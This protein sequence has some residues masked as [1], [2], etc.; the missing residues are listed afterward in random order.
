MVKYTMY[1]HHSLRPGLFRALFLL[2][3]NIVGV[4]LISWNLRRERIPT[5]QIPQ[6]PEPYRSHLIRGTYPSSFSK[7]DYQERN[8][9]QE[10]LNARVG[11]SFSQ[12]GKYVLTALGDTLR[13]YDVASGSQ[14]RAWSLPTTN[15]PGQIHLY[16][17][18]L[19]NRWYLWCYDPSLPPA[20]YSVT[21][22]QQD[23]GNPLRGL[24]SVRSISPSGRYLLG[25]MPYSSTYGPEPA[26]KMSLHDRQ[27]R[28]TA[29]LDSPESA[30]LTAYDL[31]YDSGAPR[32]YGRDAKI[33]QFYFFDL[34][35]GKR[36]PTP[37]WLAKTESQ[38]CRFLKDTVLTAHKDGTIMV[39]SRANPE[40]VLQSYPTGIRNFK[41]LGIT[42]DREFIIVEGTVSL[43][44]GQANTW[45][46]KALDT[47]GKGRHQVFQRAHPTTPVSGSRTDD[48]LQVFWTGAYHLN[49]SWLKDSRYLRG[50]SYI[51][52]LNSQKQVPL[53]WEIG[54]FEAAISPNK[55]YLAW[56][57]RHSGDL[58]IWRTPF[59]VKK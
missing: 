6:V 43:K 25:D 10:R 52:D 49:R 22:D 50:E 59:S 4:A 53:R 15:R 1:P 13:L 51:G 37:E 44:P 29:V 2:L 56:T 54:A 8:R 16:S 26:L 40:R 31:L 57:D 23:L 19:E 3:I 34:E 47:T 9:W 24:S 33:Q 35:T 38:Y 58:M 42:Q 5:H 14:V 11:P 45:F 20:V 30:T 12:D 46:S 41:R 39:R 21:P 7:P 18:P 32:L 17:V 48:I 36:L 28:R 55:E 27:T